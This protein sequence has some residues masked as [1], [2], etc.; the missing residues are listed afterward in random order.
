MKTKA[1]KLKIWVIRK[2][3]TGEHLGRTRY[4]RWTLKTPRIFTRKSDL[5]AHL[6]YAMKNGKLF[7]ES[8][9]NLSLREFDLDNL[10][11]RVDPLEHYYAALFERGLK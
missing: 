4:R 10:T 7:G 1:V 8:L 6:N 2:N 5:S 3:D 11:E 9:S